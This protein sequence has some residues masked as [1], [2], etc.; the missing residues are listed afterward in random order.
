MFRLAALSLAAIGLLAVG[1]QASLAGGSPSSA[2][3][4]PPGTPIPISAHPGGVVHSHGIG[5]T[6]PPPGEGVALSV[7]TT[8]GSAN[9]HVWTTKRGQVWELNGS[10]VSQG[11]DSGGTPECSDSY[12]PAAEGWRY[13]ANFPLSYYV[14]EST[15]PSGMTKANLYT[16]LQT[17]G[18]N[19][20]IE[21]N[22]C[23]RPTAQY[24]T[25]TAYAGNQERNNNM[26]SSGNCT[27]PDGVS[28]V[29]F[30]TGL[31]AGAIAA[32]CTWSSN[33]EATESDLRLNSS[34]NWITDEGSG[35]KTA[36]NIDNIVTHERG[37]SF[38]LDDVYTSGHNQLTMWG[39]ASPCAKNKETLALGDM[40]R[41]ED[42]YN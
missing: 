28:M 9:L 30:G 19:W 38:G 42:L 34:L 23:G 2:S 29:G 13:A 5:V 24:T 16:D 10:P 31:P 26:D 1:A 35:C 11:S 18:N 27:A 39:Y 3:G 17:A 15:I 4:P 41:F 33:G 7:L 12:E 36:Y 32:T 6:V 8:H 37:H 20:L 14:H 21:H 40:L 22:S 25:G